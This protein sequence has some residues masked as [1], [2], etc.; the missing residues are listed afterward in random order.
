MRKTIVTIDFWRFWKK[1]TFFFV[2]WILMCLFN[3]F[4]AN[5]KLDD[6]FQAYILSLEIFDWWKHNINQ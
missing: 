6:V 3:K 5:C 4:K 2:E 1:N